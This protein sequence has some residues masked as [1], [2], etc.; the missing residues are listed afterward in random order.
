M[1]TI[2]LILYAMV[3]IGLWVEGKTTRYT[4]RLDIIVGSLFWPIAIGMLLA[5]ALNEDEKEKTQ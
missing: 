5:H 2:T 3:V 1:V 4:S